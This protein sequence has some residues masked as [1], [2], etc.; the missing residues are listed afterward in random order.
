MK[1]QQIA[2]I[3][4]P[5][6]G[7]HPKDRIP[8]LVGECLDAERF[9]PEVV[10]TERPGHATEL[11]AS[12][13]SRGYSCVVA[14]GGDGTVNE[15]ACGLLHTSTALGIVPT[16]SGNGLARHLGIPIDPRRAI[17]QLNSAVVSA[18]DY[19]LINGHPFFCTCGV[20]F[21][22]HVSRE[23]ATVKTRGFL[24]YVRKAT[25][26][27]F[28]YRPQQYRLQSEE[29]VLDTTAFLIT[30]GNASQWGN[31][32]YVAP[33]ASLHDG[34]LDV[35]VLSPVG[36]FPAIEEGAKL[37]TRRIGNDHHVATWTTRELVI[38]SDEDVPSHLD[39]EPFG[40]MREVCIRIVPK[41]LKVFCAEGFQ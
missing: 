18:I 13:A 3:I 12:Y 6:S 38:H 35:V 27:F 21:D 36:L 24:S 28:S 30:V 20:G 7:T 2:F 10:F 41:G 29:R 39:G 19:G 31:E 33:R 26:A 16:G 8:A 37:F 14:V 9:A 11:A 1:Q 34:L 5:H 32:A 17:R 4:N 25:E 15:T 22:A 40:L 23:F